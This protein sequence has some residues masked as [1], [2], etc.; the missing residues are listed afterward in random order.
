MSRYKGI[1]C[2]AYVLEIL[3]LFMVQETPGLLPPVLRERPVPAGPGCL[4]AGRLRLRFDPD[5]QARVEERPVDDPRMA[6]CFRGS[7]YRLM[8]QA[9]PAARHD[10]T[11][12]AQADARP[13]PIHN[14]Q[15]A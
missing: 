6:R 1:R 10:R 9:P 12:T 13:A 14:R 8:L 5:L 7:L 11:F 4:C 2:F 3:V 15:E